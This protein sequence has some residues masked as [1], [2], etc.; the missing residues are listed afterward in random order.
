VFIRNKTS[1]EVVLAHGRLVDTR[2]VGAV[3]VRRAYRHAGGV[4]VPSDDHP[5]PVPTDPPDTSAHALWRGTS[6]TVAGDVYASPTATAG[7]TVTLTVGQLS[8]RLAVFGDRWW[9]RDRAGVLRASAPAPFE[10]LSLSFSLAF[11]GAFEVPPGLFPGTDLPFP[12]GRVRYG[13]NDGGVGFYSDEAAAE[14][15]ALPNFELADQ[16]IRAW[17]DRPVPGCFA[18]C[19]DLHALRSAPVEGGSVDPRA[20]E[21]MFEGILRSL[22]HAPGYLVFDDLPPGTPICLDGLGHE[23]VRVNLPPPPARV[24]LRRGVT[25]SDTRTRLRSVHVDAG[26]SLVTCVWGYSFLYESGAAPSWILVEA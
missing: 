21:A 19:P 15:G 4:L 7:G 2:C 6:V 23:A 14:G 1:F 18:P 10:S 26:R 16:L 20:P 24:R 3:I 8:R 22:H 17:T 11:G 5:S 9:V 25:T 12:G 13:L